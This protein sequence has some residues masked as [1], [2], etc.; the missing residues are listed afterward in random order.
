MTVGIDNVNVR[1]KQVDHVCGT[2]TRRSDSINSAGDSMY[3]IGLTGYICSGIKQV[4]HVWYN[5]KK[6]RQYK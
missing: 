6:I 4:D 1:I 5:H 2:T 3:M